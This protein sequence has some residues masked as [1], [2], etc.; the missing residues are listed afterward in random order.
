M[1]NEFRPCVPLFE[2]VDP[3]V[4]RDQFRDEIAA[5]IDNLGDD[6]LLASQ[7]DSPD[8]PRARNLLA[9]SGGLNPLSRMGLAD[10]RMLDLSATE[11][12]RMLAIKTLASRLVERR[13]T[14]IK[15]L[16]TAEALANEI[17]DR[18]LA[19]EGEHVGLVG[20]DH[21]GIRTLD[22][23]LYVGTV[24][25]SQISPREIMREALRMD[26]VTL[27]FWIWQPYPEPAYDASLKALIQELRMLGD[28]TG[29]KVWDALIV[30]ESRA[31][32]IR[33]FEGWA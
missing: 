25:N 10:H 20:V 22:R 18:S 5:E 30:G 7:L 12:A 23:L 26:A 27:V 8:L 24:N 28:V 3:D 16:T 31:L 13:M 33:T 32:S 21:R 17:V 2:V 1:E 9:R 19:W 11:S 15:S 29:A 6:W 14:E 4:F